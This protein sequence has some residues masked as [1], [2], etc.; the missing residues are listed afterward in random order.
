MVSTYKGTHKKNRFKD[1]PVE[2]KSQSMR[3]NY[4]GDYFFK[5]NGIISIKSLYGRLKVPY[6]IGNRLK[7]YL[8]S[9][10]WE[11]KSA[12]L[13]IRNNNVIFLNIVIKTEIKDTSFLNK[14][15]LVGI[16]LGIN[17]LAMITDTKESTAF[18]GGEKVKYLR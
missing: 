14:N 12:V 1:I 5:E 3:L 10:E 7:E 8:N 4:P 18:Y 15:G 9:D 17:F 13:A 16:D 11:I 6:K 2:F